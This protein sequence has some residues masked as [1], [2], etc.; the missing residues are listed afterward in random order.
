A[1]ESDVDCRAQVESLLAAHARAGDFLEQPA[2][3][4]PNALPP[5]ADAV[6]PGMRIGAYRVDRE[7]GRGGM[8][9]VF[10]AVRDDD[11]FRKQVAIK[12]LDFGIAKLIAP[13]PLVAPTVTALRMLTPEYAS[14]EQVRGD[15]ITTSTDVY[16]LG[17][18][19]YRL[20]TDRG[21]YRLRTGAPHELAE[22]ILDQE[23]AQPSAVV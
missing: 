2:V 20:L 11:Q 19:L 1:C 7:L 23:P 21:P 8:G 14:P 6:R 5:D 12:L 15:A 18:L 16:A 10:L 17:V 22:A 3:V 4:D 13:Q 9:A